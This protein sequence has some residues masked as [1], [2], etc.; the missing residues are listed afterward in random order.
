M[1]S[2]SRCGGRVR[3]WAGVGG[4]LAGVDWGGIFFCNF[5]LLGGV[6]EGV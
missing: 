6:N 5:T 1:R 3:G 4:S 2:W